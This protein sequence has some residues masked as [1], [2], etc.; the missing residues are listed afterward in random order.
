QDL[1]KS[2]NAL[3]VVIDVEV[4][5]LFPNNPPQLLALSAESTTQDSPDAPV[6]RL[7]RLGRP[8]ITNITLAAN[9]DDP[10][11][12]DQYNADRPFAVPADHA[13]AYRERVAKN[14]ALFDRADGRSDWTDEN[15]LA[16]AN[17]LVDDFLVVDIA[18]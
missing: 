7:D 14:L 2:T 16:L 10:D 5:K 12:R 15:R 9:D 18:L 3:A 1:M 8:E 13:R 11:L 4:Q 6:R 17:L